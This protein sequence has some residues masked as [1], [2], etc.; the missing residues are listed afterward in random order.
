MPASVIH[1][2]SE[3]TLVVQQS[4]KR[5]EQAIRV[6]SVSFLFWFN[7]HQQ[8]KGL[9]DAGRSTYNGVEGSQR[10]THSTRTRWLH[11]LVYG[12]E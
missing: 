6:S 12:A 11:L 9:H 7:V 3:L 5:H 8:D 4:G 2:Q 10:C 1:L